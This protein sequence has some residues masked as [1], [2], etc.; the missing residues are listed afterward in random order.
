[1]TEAELSWMSE[2]PAKVAVTFPE[3]GGN[4][5]V[6]NLATLPGMRLTL[7]STVFPALNITGPLGCAVGDVILAVN[8]TAW[9]MLD[10][11]GEEV[12]VAELVA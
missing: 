12:S 1:V 2:S 6:V 8:V 3:P 5:E 10:G 4:D 11:F 7:P 9:P